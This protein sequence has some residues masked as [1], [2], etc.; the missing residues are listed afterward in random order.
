MKVPEEPHRHSAGFTCT[1]LLTLLIHCQD[2]P[3]KPSPKKQ[4]V[5][6]SGKGTLK[7][8]PPPK[9][10]AA[11]G[12]SAKS[13]KA[14]A[15]K[16]TSAKQPIKGRSKA[17]PKKGKKPQQILSDSEESVSQESDSEFSAKEVCCCT[18]ADARGLL[19]GNNDAL[20]GCLICFVACTSC[21]EPTAL[22][23][24]NGSNWPERL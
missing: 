11:S 7:E 12:K 13:P 3:T 16:G 21:S 20:Q 23:G 14:A 4:K 19:S 9:K 6:P 1:D 18:S 24:V 2:E 5:T 10:A 17:T 22:Q 8:A 15:A